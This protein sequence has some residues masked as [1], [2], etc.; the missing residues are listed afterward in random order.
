MVDFDLELTDSDVA[1]FLLQ[2]HVEKNKPSPIF[3]QQI[4]AGVVEH[5]PFQNITMLTG[6][7]QRPSKSWIKEEMLNGLG[8][9]CT[10][11]NPFLYCLLKCLGFEVRF[12]SSTILEPDDH[13]SLVVSINEEE[14][15]VDV[16]N[17]YPYFS[18]IR[19][20][21]E[22]PQSNWF[23]QYRLVSR[24]ARYEVQHALPGEEWSLNH[25]FSPAAVDFSVFDHMHEMHYK[26]P[27]WGP[28]LTGIRVNR[29][30][31]EG[32]AIL[33][34]HRATSPTGMEELDEPQQIHSWLKQWFGPNFWNQ[35]D[36]NLA[37]KRWK[38][39]SQVV[40]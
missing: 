17:G 1:S 38:N 29:F 7:R 6:P 21:D 20:G 33:K 40:K 24:G 15:W 18:P 5:V 13:I 37:Y 2:I 8:G 27:G 11:R 30:W 36:L 4:I 3:L 25:H 35:I 12:V 26:Q 28:F 10:V 31:P 22:S 19:L 39:P 23:F 14:W 34:D 9:L 32:G 16:G